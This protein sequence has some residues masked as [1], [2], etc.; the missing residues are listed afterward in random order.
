MP[1]FWVVAWIRNCF[2]SLFSC[3][4]AILTFATSI[5]LRKDKLVSSWQLSHSIDGI[6]ARAHSRLFTKM[7]SD[8]FTR[9]ICS[10]LWEIRDFIY[11]FQIDVLCGLFYVLVHTEVRNEKTQLKREQ[12][13]WKAAVEIHGK[14]SKSELE[15][16]LNER[17][18]K[19]CS[20]P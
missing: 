20:D 1:T 3:F 8:F 11:L 4:H 13:K 15:K 2:T 5:F 9:T 18:Q 16:N 19:K 14:S 7:L 17:W 12:K 6:K 10:I